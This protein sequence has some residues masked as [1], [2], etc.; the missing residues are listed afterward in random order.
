MSEYFY[1]TQIHR[2]TPMAKAYCFSEDFCTSIS[3]PNDKALNRL[4]RE[5][6]ANSPEW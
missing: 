1:L 2:G 4:Y 6:T 5:L 3:M